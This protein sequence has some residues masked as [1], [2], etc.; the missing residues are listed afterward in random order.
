MEEVFTKTITLY[1]DTYEYEF[2]D[3]FYPYPEEKPELTPIELSFYYS[4]KKNQWKQYRKGLEP[5]I[6]GFDSHGEAVLRLLNV[7]EFQGS[8]IVNLY[9]LL[10][11]NAR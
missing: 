8:H 4:P 11:Y 5:V 2:G 6:F 10:L 9:D 1:Y 7:D 3:G